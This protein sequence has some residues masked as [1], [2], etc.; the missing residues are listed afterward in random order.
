MQEQISKKLGE[1]T[2]TRHLAHGGMSEVYLAHTEDS[3]QVY[4]LKL[5][6]H[7]DEEC[8][9]RFQREVQALYKAQHTHILPLLD[10]GEA[11]G[12]SY[13]VMPYIEQGTLKQHLSAGP[14]SLEEAEHILAQIGE[15]L[16]FLH[17]SGVVHRD[18]KPANILLDEDGRAWLA[19][20]GLVKTVEADQ[21]L[22]K[23]GFVIGTPSY[24]APEL[25]S[26]P[27]SVSSDIYALGVVLYEMLTGRQP[28]D[29]FTPLEICVK[30]ANTPPLPP[31]MLNPQIPPAV[32][33]VVLQAL[34]KDPQARFKASM[35][36]VEAYRQ[37]RVCPDPPMLTWLAD[38]AGAT[39]IKSISWNVPV[40]T[41]QA[42][43]RALIVALLLIMLLMLGAFTL[44]I[45]A[46]SLYSSSA[47]ITAI[48]HAATTTS[49]AAANNADAVRNISTPAPAPPTTRPG[50]QNSLPD[51]P[52]GKHHDHGHGGGGGDGGND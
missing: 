46:H 50:P 31:S 2:L 11:N 13:Y 29:G 52:P 41:E 3:E 12:F 38:M 45:E 19:D 14:L 22:T 44:V 35:E 10:Y 1:Y 24:M 9:Q 49:P 27:A 28:F 25:L 48:H 43:R 26:Q 18:I 30:H 21:D 42:H 51:N 16:Q 7:T 36:L 15:A 20:L 32:E 37:A 33:R 40:P 39:T 47:R 8:Y 34:A 4:A 6:E 17:E 23:T 5:V